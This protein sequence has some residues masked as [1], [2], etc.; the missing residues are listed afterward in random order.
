MIFSWI[1]FLYVYQRVSH[2]PFF[3]TPIPNRTRFE[4]KDGSDHMPVSVTW[5]GGRVSLFGVQKNGG[6]GWKNHQLKD[7]TT[8]M[9]CV[10]FTLEG[11]SELDGIGAPLLESHHMEARSMVPRVD[12]EPNWWSPGSQGHLSLHHSE[13]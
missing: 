9:R 10:G 4:D 5:L 7:F 2:S 8:F 6:V 12:G 11:K 3:L 1:S 13:M